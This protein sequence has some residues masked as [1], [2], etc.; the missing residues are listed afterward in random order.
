MCIRD[1][2]QRRVHGRNPLSKNC[3][4]QRA[5]AYYFRRPLTGLYH[6]P[7]FHRIST[8]IIRKA[9]D[10]SRSD[11]KYP[12]QRNRFSSKE[13]NKKEEKHYSG[14]SLMEYWHKQSELENKYKEIMQSLTLEEAEEIKL[15]S[16][17]NCKFRQ[18][19]KSIKEEYKITRRLMIEQKLLEQ[20]ELLNFYSR[21]L[22]TKNAQRSFLLN[23]IP[24][25]LSSIYYTCL[26]YTSPS[27]RDLS[28]SRMPSSA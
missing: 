13:S 1:R 24:S 27:P 23:F 11:A 22:L 4:S 8:K 3:R 7:C 21:N 9:S 20:E 18:S 5:R 28:T 26:L 12:F 25:L 6:R 16:S 15:V 2:Y 10:N 17:T 14:T 19:V